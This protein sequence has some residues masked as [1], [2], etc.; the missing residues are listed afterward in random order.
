MA[1]TVDEYFLKIDKWKEELS[2]LRTILLDCLLQEEIKWGNPC[3]TYNGKNIILLGGFKNYC[4]ISFIKGSLL[5]DA[6]NILSQQGENTQS[7]RVIKFTSIA[8]IQELTAVIKSYIF[9]AVEVEKLG[10]KVK[11]SKSTELELPVELTEFMN[12]KTAFKTAFYKLSPGRQ[13]GYILH[14]SGAKKSETRTA[15]IESCEQRILDGYGFRDCTCG[16]SK[17]KPN[18]DGSHKTLA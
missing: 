5:K 1:K 15:R 18:C 10:L 14:F 9:E 11:F 13:K 12:R 7:A 16:L 17:R 4:V 6:E 3:Y 8:E 2:E